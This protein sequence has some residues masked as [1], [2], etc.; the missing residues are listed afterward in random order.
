MDLI[1]WVAIITSILASFLSCQRQRTDAVLVRV[2]KNICPRTWIRADFGDKIQTEKLIIPC[3]SMVERH[4][5]K[6]M[7]PGSSPGGGA[8]V[9]DRHNLRS[10][11]TVLSL[12]SAVFYLQAVS[13]EV[14]A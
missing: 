5:V 12:R 9:D 14:L 13:S 3:S 8:R 1:F 10:R 6:M 4:P 11:Q 2:A 7:V